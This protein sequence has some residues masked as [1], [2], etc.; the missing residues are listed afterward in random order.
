MTNRIAKREIV[1]SDLNNHFVVIN[2]IK[3]GSDF[4]LYKGG[5]MLK[6]Y[7]NVIHC[8]YISNEYTLLNAY[9]IF[10]VTA[11]FFQRV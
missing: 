10:V 7:L 1:Y 9:T 3:Y 5:V 6:I 2:D 11:L 4:V 8:C